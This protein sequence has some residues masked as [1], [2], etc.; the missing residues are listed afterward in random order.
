MSSDLTA[1]GGPWQPSSACP[2]LILAGARLYAARHAIPV[3][4]ASARQLFAAAAAGAQESARLAGKDTGR[5]GPAVATLEDL[6]GTDWVPRELPFMV[7]CQVPVYLFSVLETALCDCLGLAAAAQQVPA[8]E[9]VKGPKIE[10]YLKALADA[11]DV[12]VEWSAELWRDLKLW[13]SRRNSLAHGLSFLLDA[14]STRN[15]FAL[16]SYWTAGAPP[17]SAPLEQLLR[18]IEAAIEGVDRA[19]RGVMRSL[20]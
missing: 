6:A 11:C 7:L 1:D 19:M 9:I 2:P 10:G 8:P 15:E 4:A 17:G 20:A 12:P 5:P 16:E 18:L 3:L 13:R 14:D